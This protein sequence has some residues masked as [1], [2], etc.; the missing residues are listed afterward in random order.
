MTAPTVSHGAPVAGQVA[1]VEAADQT[2]RP[3]LAST[4]GGAGLDQGQGDG[5]RVEGRARSAAARGDSHCAHCGK[6][7]SPG[8]HGRRRYCSNA[9]R[10][11]AYKRRQRSARSAAGVTDGT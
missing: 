4:S 2:A 9:C 10:T 1:T 11:G 5:G 3:S 6:R 7:M 8:R